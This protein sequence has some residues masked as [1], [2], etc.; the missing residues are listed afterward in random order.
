MT[1]TVV[2][3]FLFVLTSQLEIILL[4]RGPK[5]FAVALSQAI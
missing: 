1:L 5:M 2:P 4:L 3:P